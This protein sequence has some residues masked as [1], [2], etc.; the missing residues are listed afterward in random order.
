VKFLIDTNILLHAANSASP[1]HLAAR[2]F[3]QQ[4]LQARTPWCITWPI[5][6]EF[7]RV[8]THFRVFPKPLK[9]KQALDFIVR[10]TSIEELA[11]LTATHRHLE[12][13]THV[14]A[15]LSH[16]A[17]NLFHDIHTA[18]L[19]RE[20]GVSEIVTADSDFRQFGFLKVTNPLLG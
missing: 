1:D 19:M 15:G 3:L 12:V 2:H 7:L 9:A 8:S 20:H 5:L 18:A 16:P 14:I 10:L 6:Y 11:I 4:H 17:G 13:L